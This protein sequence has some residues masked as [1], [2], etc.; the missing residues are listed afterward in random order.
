MTNTFETIEVQSI[1]DFLEKTLKTQNEWNS[2]SERSR[3]A[4]FRGVKD[5][6]FTLTP[7]Y[8]RFRQ[9][10]KNRHEDDLR[11]EFLRRSLPLFQEKPPR[12]HWEWYFAMQHYDIPT[13]LLDW[14]ESSFVG[15]FF[16]VYDYLALKQGRLD[17]DS[18][19]PPN[20]KNAAVWMMDA[21]RF[22]EVMLNKQRRPLFNPDWPIL[23]YDDDNIADYLSVRPGWGM[24]PQDGPRVWPS[25]PIAIMPP[26]SNPRLTA[27]RGM[28]V[29]FGQDETPLEKS[30][31][32]SEND[33]ARLIK[34][35][36]PAECI[37]PFQDSL[38]SAGITPSLLFPE[39]QMMSA[40]IMQ[41]L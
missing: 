32:W 29:L 41:V 7:S 37:K 23:R 19:S 17:H 4:W 22:N 24:S 28:F 15:L 35:E 33:E 13:R 27:Q 5:T 31:N 16:A 36:I 14:S 30:M 6:T 8:Y 38:R 11:D 39:L 25:E 21:V 9:K 10:N 1:G 3:L 12:D 2:K 34:F 20:E 18:E 26:C 40:E